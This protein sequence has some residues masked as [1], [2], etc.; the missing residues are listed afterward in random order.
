MH[1]TIN[2]TG[3]D[4]LVELP[5]EML[6]YL[7]PKTRESLVDCP[8]GGPAGR[9][10]AVPAGAPHR[11]GTTGEPGAYVVLA[12]EGTLTIAD[13]FELDGDFWME[14]SQERFS[15]DAGASL[16]LAPLGAVT[17]AGC[18]DISGAGVVGS[19]QLTGG[20]ALG[21]LTVLGAA[22]FEINTTAAAVTIQRYQFD[23]EERMV[24]DQ[25]VNVTLP[26]GTTRIFVGGLLELS[27]AFTLEGQFEFVNNADVISLDVD[28]RFDAFGGCYLTVDGSARIVKGENPGLVLALDADLE[29]SF[30]GI[31]GVFDLDAQL[32]L[33]VNTR[34]GVGPDDYD[35]GIERGTFR[36]AVLGELNLLSVLT[37]EGSGFIE[38]SQGVFRMDVTMDVNFF[39]IGQLDV[40]GFFSSEGEFRIYVNGEVSLGAGMRVVRLGRA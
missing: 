16:A 38:M 39:G 24:S 29:S 8:D 20:L 7:P 21:P 9:C 15:L 5:E 11:D 30:F 17:A 4:Q 34:G 36:V 18:L 10:Y 1:V 26:A 35:L 37:L 25:K 22:Q 32:Q 19:L 3:E 12:A 33:E 40:N 28:A 27:G 6:G 2:V 23:F 14:V 13:A 31:A